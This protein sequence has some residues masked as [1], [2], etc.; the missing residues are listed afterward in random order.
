MYYTNV[1]RSDP[2]WEGAPSQPE[3]AWGQGI[4]PPVNR[5][6]WQAGDMAKG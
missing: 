1:P 3:V 5:E 4:C 6:G 2:Y